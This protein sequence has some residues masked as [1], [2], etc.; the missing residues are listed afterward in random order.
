MALRTAGVKPTLKEHPLRGL[1]WR[2]PLWRQPGVSSGKEG[3]V[4]MLVEKG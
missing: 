2:S 3:K 1:Q 4:V